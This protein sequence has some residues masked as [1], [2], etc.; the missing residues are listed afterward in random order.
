LACFFTVRLLA[1]G[2]LQ[3]A[4]SVRQD[5]RKSRADAAALGTPNSVWRGTAE[6]ADALN[7]AIERGKLNYLPRNPIGQPGA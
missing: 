3:Q 1:A 7:I 5:V 6:A 4:N 2:Q